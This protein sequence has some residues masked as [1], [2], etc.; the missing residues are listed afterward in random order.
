MSKRKR[1]GD[2]LRVGRVFPSSVSRQ[3]KNCFF[4]NVYWQVM[5]IK[6]RSKR[7]EEEIMSA[8]DSARLL[9]KLSKKLDDMNTTQERRHEELCSK[10]AGLEQ[11]TSTLATDLK[12]LKEGLQS[13]EK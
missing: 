10:L 9:E 13:L 8:G 4:F 3:R 12:E 1:P 11:K 5:P 2:E 7:G 6:T